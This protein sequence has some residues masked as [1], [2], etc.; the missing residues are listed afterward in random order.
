MRSTKIHKFIKYKSDDLRAVYYNSYKTRI[1]GKTKIQICLLGT[2][3]VDGK[4]DREG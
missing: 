2:E 4:K 3:V 1:M